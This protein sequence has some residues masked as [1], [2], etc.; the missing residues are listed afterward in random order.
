MRKRVATDNLT[1][2][3]TVATLQPDN[4]RE[5]AA[6]LHHQS[7]NYLC[8]LLTLKK[9]GSELTSNRHKEEDRHLTSSWSSRRMPKD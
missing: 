8:V 2:R 9:K 7:F 6:T 3:E 5:R 4:N 1:I